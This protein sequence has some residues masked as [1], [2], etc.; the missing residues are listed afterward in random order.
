MIIRETTHHQSHASLHSIG[1]G[2]NVS[3]ERCLATHDNFITSIS[4]YFRSRV[5]YYF[6]ITCI[7]LD[8]KLPPCSEC[9]ILTFGWFPG[10][11]DSP[12]NKNI[13]LRS[14]RKFEIKNNSLLCGGNY[15]THSTIR[16]TP[17]QEN[18]T[19]HLPY[20]PSS[21]QRSRHHTSFLTVPSP[22]PLSRRQ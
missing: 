10:A 22:H 4:F 13:T 18:Q 1:R 11:G 5:S 12:K 9:C 8:F 17:D 16:K 3:L 6:T 19:P 21:L 20:F 14:G 2:T 7:F 15:L